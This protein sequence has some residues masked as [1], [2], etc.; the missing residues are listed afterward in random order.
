MGLTNLMEFYSEERFKNWIKKIEECEARE[1]D[2]KTFEVFDHFVEDF[3]IACFKL[4][5]AV[6]NR[7]VS[8]KMALE[9]LND[10]RKI[11]LV[12]MDFGDD[13]KNE[14]YEFARESIKTIANSVSYYLQNKISKKDFKQLLKE[15]IDFEREGE[16][17]AAF[18]TVAKMGAKV[19]KGEELPE[20]E[21]DG[22]VANWLDGVETLAM[23]MKIMKIDQHLSNS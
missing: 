6:K 1:D 22:F 15:A 18:D 14:F 8:K 7:E 4:I 16:V 23:M 20:L 19:L 3:A 12:S 2:P 5:S 11:F 17:Q 10:V 9:I 13:L 21:A